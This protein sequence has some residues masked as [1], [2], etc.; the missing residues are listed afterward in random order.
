MM[1]SMLYFTRA[2]LH[3]QTYTCTLGSYAIFTHAQFPL[4]TAFQT[5]TQF[6]DKVGLL[7][8]AINMFVLQL[9]VEGGS[10][11]IFEL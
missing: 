2:H 1:A 6:W 10:Y 4:V 7:C 8:S 3:H 11:R 9:G 5:I